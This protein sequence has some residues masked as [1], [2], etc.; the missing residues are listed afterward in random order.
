MPI[1]VCIYAATTSERAEEIASQ[2][3]ANNQREVDVWG[4]S[5]PDAPWLF[6]QTLPGSS[7]TTL[8]ADRPL[9]PALHQEVI[10]AGEVVVG[11]ALPPSGDAGAFIGSPKY[12]QPCACGVAPEDHGKAGFKRHL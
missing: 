11:A 5:T 3:Q 6:Q 2:V 12:V 4:Q 8:A 1:S 7:D 10:A 9:H